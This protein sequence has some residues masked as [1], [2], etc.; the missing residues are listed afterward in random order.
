MVVSHFGVGSSLILIRARRHRQLVRLMSRQYAQLGLGAR[1]LCH[2]GHADDLS[3]ALKGPGPGGSIIAGGDVVAA[4]MKEVVDL[5][6]GG[7]EAL[8]L[9]G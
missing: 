9:A 4:E 7:E 3:P 1:P 2:S 5:V 6:V 8:R